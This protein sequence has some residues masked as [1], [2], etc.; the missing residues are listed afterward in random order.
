VF[1]PRAS[2]PYWILFAIV[3]AS[4]TSSNPITHCVEI[5]RKIIE[6]STSKWKLISDRIKHIFY[7]LRCELMT[8]FSIEISQLAPRSYARS[9]GA[10]PV[11]I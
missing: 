3:Q 8:D 10:I 11:E 6:L 5:W 7:V 1:P 2:K 9:Y 4:R